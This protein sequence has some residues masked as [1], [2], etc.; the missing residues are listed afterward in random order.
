MSFSRQL[1]EWNRD[2]WNI[3][4]FQI[5]GFLGNMFNIKIDCTEVG[6][7]FCFVQYM[8]NKYVEGR[9]LSVVKSPCFPVHLSIFCKDR[10]VPVL[11]CS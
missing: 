2:E 1:K 7:L 4:I 5:N 10:C 11:I 9:G 6:M 8:S 3:W